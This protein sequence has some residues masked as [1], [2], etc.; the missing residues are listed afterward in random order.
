MGA[1]KVAG[2]FGIIL[3]V[4]TLIGVVISF[5]T[6]FGFT[7]SLKSSMQSG[8]GIDS[9]LDAFQQQAKTMLNIATILMLI[10]FPL[11]IGFL[12][13]FV[14]LGKKFNNRMLLT[15]GWIFIVLA[16][17]G[18]ILT[19]AFY[20]TGN[21]YPEKQTTSASVGF[22]GLLKQKASQEPVMGAILNMLGDAGFLPLLILFIVGGLALKISFGVGLYKLKKNELALG[23]WSGS[24]EIGSLIVSGLGTIAM[25]L[26]TIMFF[27]A[28]KKF[29]Q[30]L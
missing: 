20:A 2:I 10:A 26:E 8:Q 6:F 14:A 4:I 5:S 3:L 21:L 15:T 27:Q 17:L 18:F 28:S 25:L 11:S 23:G 13:G 29:E 12:Y 22:V 1:L 7:S 19:L 30:T 16:I 9:G 24:F